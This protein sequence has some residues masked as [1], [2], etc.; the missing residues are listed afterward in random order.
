MRYIIYISFSRTTLFNGKNVKE[1]L[2]RPG[3][4]LVVPRG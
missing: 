3:E 4:A 1:S 2:Y